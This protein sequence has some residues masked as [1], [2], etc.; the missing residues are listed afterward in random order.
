MTREKQLIWLRAGA[1]L[2]IASGVLVGFG[3]HPATAGLARL[4]ADVL[5]WPLEGVQTGAADETRLLAAIGGGVMIGWGLLLWQL[6]G[7]PSA[8]RVIRMSVIAW[9]VAD[10]AGSL[11]AGAPLNVVGNLVFLALFMIPLLRAPR[12]AAA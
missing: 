1:V 6:A 5:F 8:W 11:A 4:L 10:S 7:E 2:V 12:V 9:F 3:S